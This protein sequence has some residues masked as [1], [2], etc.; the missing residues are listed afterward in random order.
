[1]NPVPN[2]L[3]EIF[4]AA[5]IRAVFANGRKAQELYRRFCYHQTGMEAIFLP[6]TS[7]AN[8]GYSL[9]RLLKEWSV[10]LEYLK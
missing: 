9:D 10:I 8:A 5:G 4:A 2:D 3:S 1:M 6:S 7:P